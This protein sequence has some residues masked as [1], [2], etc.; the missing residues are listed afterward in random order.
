MP[1]L[2][3]PQCGND[4]FQD[5]I[6]CTRCAWVRP[7]AEQAHARA[8]RDTMGGEVTEQVFEF[9]DLATWIKSRPKTR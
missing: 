7:D 2:Y 6:A 3:C 9:T 8:I 4:L 1:S 5:D